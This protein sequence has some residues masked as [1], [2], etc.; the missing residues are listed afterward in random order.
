MVTSSAEAEM[1]GIFQNTQATIP[2]RHI[3]EA[4]GHLQD[5]TRIKTDN[6]TAC[7]FVGNNIISRRSKTWDMRYHWVREKQE[8]GTV[9]V[10][11][12]KG[13]DN[14]AD[15]FTKH[16]QASYHCSIRPRYLRDCINCIFE[17]QISAIW[18]IAISF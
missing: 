17:K 10:Y 1:G 5:P 16:F 9:L 14:D 15:Y 4:L 2:I 11:W 18:N 12:V 13:S 8:D 3:I 7:G 6:S